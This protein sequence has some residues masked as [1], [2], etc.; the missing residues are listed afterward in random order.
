MIAQQEK[1]GTVLVEHRFFGESNPYNNLSTA[2]LSLL[3]INQSIAD[4]VY[5]AEH[6]KLPMPG[7]DKVSPKQAPWI[8]VGGSYAGALTA[9]TKVA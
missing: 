2:S 4:M 7:G 3:N 5:F 9:W 6:V 8:M 1:G